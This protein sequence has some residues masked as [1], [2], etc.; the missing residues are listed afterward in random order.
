MSDIK[1]PFVD[2]LVDK[3]VWAATSGSATWTRVFDGDHH[4]ACLEVIKRLRE[5][6]LYDVTVT[7]DVSD[8]RI[9]I[10]VSAKRKPVKRKTA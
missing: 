1:N 2:I 3:T 4:T 5:F 7:P 6:K 10:S 9:T 8:G